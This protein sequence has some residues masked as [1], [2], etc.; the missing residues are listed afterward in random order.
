LK[1]E[2]FSRTAYKVALHGAAYQLFDQPRVLKDSLAVP[3]VAAEAAEKLLASQENAIT[4]LMG[5][6]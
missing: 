1:Q 4:Q 2:R 3:I 6:V 5:W